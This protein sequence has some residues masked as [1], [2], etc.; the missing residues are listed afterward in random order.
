[1]RMLAIRWLRSVAGT[2]SSDG[3]EIRMFGRNE[4]NTTLKRAKEILSSVFGSVWLMM[5]LMA[6]FS[7]SLL[8]GW[9]AVVVCIL[10]SLACRGDCRCSVGIRQRA[11]FSGAFCFAGGAVGALEALLLRVVPT[12][13][14]TA[15]MIVA[16]GTSAEWLSTGFR[17]RWQLARACFLVF[18]VISYLIFRLYYVNAAFSNLSET[19]RA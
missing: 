16:F 9:H 13:G 15:L 18:W 8:T 11:W 2:R 6:W 3:G 7:H 19:L 12:V 1:M 10:P 5:S 14:T 4:K 17:C